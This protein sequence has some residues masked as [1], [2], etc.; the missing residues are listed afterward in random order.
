[1]KPSAARPSQPMNSVTPQDMAAGL[2]ERYNSAVASLINSRQLWAGALIV[3]CGIDTFAGLYRGREGYGSTSRDFISFVTRYMPVFALAPPGRVARSY[4]SENLRETF[5]GR[6]VWALRPEQ[7][8]GTC[9]EVLY[10]C[11][12]CGLV[13]QGITPP[14]L[15]VVDTEASSVFVFEVHELDGEV[16]YKM[17]L[18][19]RPFHDEFVRGVNNYV[20]DLAESQALETRFWRR[21]NFITGP[22][23]LIASQKSITP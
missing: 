2:A 21:W 16:A 20:R 12:R 6:L 8:V 23:W 7:P 15:N 1:M 9:A 3:C 19:I 18:N 5:E 17:S 14:G 11:Y 4:W 13:H 10:R 22:Q